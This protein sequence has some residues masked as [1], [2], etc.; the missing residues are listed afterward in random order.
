ML[1]AVLSAAVLVGSSLGPAQGDP[2]RDEVL[3]RAGRYVQAFVEEAS[4]IVAEEDYDQRASTP[5][6]VL[7]RR[8]KSDLAIVSTGSTGW[9]AFR[10]VFE[11]DGRVVRDRD[12]RLA[13]LFGAPA[14]DAFARAQQIVAE[15]ARFNLNPSDAG[16][17]R[18]INM[19]VT[20]LRFLEPHHVS[21]SEFRLDWTM[22]D[23][24]R[25]ARLRFTERARPRLIHSPDD[26][27]AA[28]TFLVDPDIGAVL[29][30]DLMIETGA[31]F[32]RVQTRYA[33]HPRFRSWL[34]AVMEDSYI[35]FVPRTQ[36]EAR[37]I[38]GRATYSNFRA[39]GVTVEVDTSARP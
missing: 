39:F 11:V 35:S 4:S 17:S 6:S 38:E 12:D 33:A 13:R 36:I 16:V 10:D 28:G 21:R 15:G 5:S 37:R 31:V 8:T 20:A 19:P 18:T 30:A 3:A 27:A 25:V 9:V 14:P 7:T 26:A 32:A 34:P 22:S 1:P 23:G 24:R 2:S 29:E